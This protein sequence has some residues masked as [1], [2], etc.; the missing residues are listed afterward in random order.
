MRSVI[1]ECDIRQAER[2]HAVILDG[3][4]E[5]TAKMPRTAIRRGTEQGEVRAD[6]ANGCVLDAISAMTTYHSK[7]CGS[8][9]PDADPEE[10]AER[11]M[12]PLL[13]PADS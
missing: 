3:L 1:H 5:S 4:V 12:V 10:T 6:A 9:W 7:M 2:F 8:E 11:L 13:R